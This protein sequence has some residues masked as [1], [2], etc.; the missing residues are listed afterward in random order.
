VASPNIRLEPFFL[1]AQPGER[2]C[3]Y[4]A[5]AADTPCRGAI[6]YV[7]PFA[8]EMNKSR[9]MVALQSRAL[10][11]LGFA[12]LQVDLYGCGD[13][14]GELGHASWEYWRQ[15]IELAA[16]WLGSRTGAPLSLWAL[17]LGALLA[18]DFA[19]SSTVCFQRFVLWQPVISGE[20][21]LTQFLRLR[22]AS[23]M[24]AH[25]KA[26][27][28]VESLRQALRRGESVEVAGYELPPALATA[29][30]EL[31]LAPL[32]SPGSTV[33][34][35]EVVPQSRQATSPASERVLS[36]WQSA[37]VHVDLHLVPGDP[38]WNTLQITECAPLLAATT[39]IW[40]AA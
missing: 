19:R 24:L 38:F 36:K 40:A 16:N 1:P 8:E 10:A 33:N 4:T 30:D 37:G 12:V 14:T 26:R 34:W 39:Q 25:G 7:P 20:L 9:R 2:F 35:L 27:T 3:V 29:L 15:D 5:P 23:E 17:R 22:G 21:H 18:L 13:S 11:A 32:A 31:N 6:L 28:T